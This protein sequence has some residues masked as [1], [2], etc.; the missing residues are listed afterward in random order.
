MQVVVEGFPLFQFQPTELSIRT[1]D[2]G[3][4]V[5]LDWE[6]KGHGQ[7]ERETERCGKLTYF[8]SAQGLNS[9]RYEM[10]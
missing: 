2:S 7:S 9:T 8:F 5:V 3:K 6:S 4:L 10:L 1:E